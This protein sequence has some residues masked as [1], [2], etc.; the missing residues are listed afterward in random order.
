MKKLVLVLVTAVITAVVVVVLLRPGA[1]R[2]LGYSNKTTGLPDRLRITAVISQFLAVKA[3][4]DA[5]LTN[6]M[7]IENTKPVYDEWTKENGATGHDLSDFIVGEG[8]VIVIISFPLG[9]VFVFRPERS[10]KSWHCAMFPP[11]TF[12][13]P[14][15]AR[16]PISMP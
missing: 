7:T 12:D 16:F 2:Y 4:A 5:A 6:Q 1:I 9:E 14:C 10:D 11:V 3:A 13:T 8:G 15:N